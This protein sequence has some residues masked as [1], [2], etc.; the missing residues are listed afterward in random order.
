MTRTHISLF[1]VLP[2]LVVSGG[3]NAMLGV[4][5]ISGQPSMVQRLMYSQTTPERYSMNVCTHLQT[6][7]HKPEHESSKLRS[8]TNY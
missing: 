1:D 2:D 8:G 5:V 7:R 6:C 3:G 4:V